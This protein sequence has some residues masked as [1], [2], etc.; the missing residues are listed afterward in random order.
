MDTKKEYI[1]HL[2]DSWGGLAWDDFPEK[3]KCHEFDSG[4]HLRRNIGRK[5]W[6]NPYQRK[7]N[8]NE[9]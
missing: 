1:K 5:T 7:G 4:M 6:K 2:R 3:R 8:G 9:S